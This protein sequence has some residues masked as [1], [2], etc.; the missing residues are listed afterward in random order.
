L[1]PFDPEPSVFL[2]AVKKFKNVNIHDYNFTFVS[3][4]EEE[5]RTEGV[6]RRVLRSM[7]GPKRNEVTGG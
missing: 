5:I 1:L 4:I 7:I 3:D 6:L 2:S